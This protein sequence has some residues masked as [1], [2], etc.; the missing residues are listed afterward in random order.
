MA[1]M[2]RRGVRLRLQADSRKRRLSIRYLFAAGAS[3]LMRMK[4]RPHADEKNTPSPRPAPGSDSEPS[5]DDG[6]AKKS[7]PEKT[8]VTPLDDDK[9]IEDGGIEIKET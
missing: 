4:E 3:N 7:P 5:R 1:A 6:P 8:Q 9:H 2:L